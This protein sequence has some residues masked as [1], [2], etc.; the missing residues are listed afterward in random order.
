[1]RI[2]LS[3]LL[4]LQAAARDIG[5]QHGFSGN[6]VLALVNALIDAEGDAA[7]WK[8]EAQRLTIQF[9]RP[10]TGESPRGP[11]GFPEEFP[12]SDLP[13]GAGGAKA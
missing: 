13:T 3:A 9:L 8:R 7:Y 1:M 11:G 4:E 12:G 2:A 6:R 5:A 10:L